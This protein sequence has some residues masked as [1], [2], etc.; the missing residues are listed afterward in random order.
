[1]TQANVD[2]NSILLE[3]KSK[4]TMNGVD[5]VDGFSDTFINLTVKGESFRI[6]G[7]KLKI[8]SFNKQSKSFMAE[9]EFREL[10]FTY[11]RTPILKKIFK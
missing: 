5:G 1:M 4:L 10:K 8:V 3:N 7:E 2:Q 9:G 11:K 6:L